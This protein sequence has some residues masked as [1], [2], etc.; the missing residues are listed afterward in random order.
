MKKLFFLTDRFSSHEKNASHT[1]QADITLESKRSRAVFPKTVL[2]FDKIA[3]EKSLKFLALVCF[4]LSKGPHFFLF[5]HHPPKTRQRTK[6]EA[7]LFFSSLSSLP[8]LKRKGKNNKKVQIVLTLLFSKRMFC[9]FSCT[10]SKKN[11]KKV[12]L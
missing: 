11:I 8:K 6:I 5:S 1:L 3:V 9:H 2:N 12:S 10:S 7:R 4:F